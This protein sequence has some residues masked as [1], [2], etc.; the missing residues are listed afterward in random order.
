MTGTV[1][2][3]RFLP[4]FYQFFDKILHLIICVKTDKSGARIYE[5]DDD[6][7]DEHL[8]KIEQY[9]ADKL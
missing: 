4:F 9:Y 7:Y 8:R 5:T 2:F 3:N 1:T 6:S